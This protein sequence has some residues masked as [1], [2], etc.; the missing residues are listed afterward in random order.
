MTNVIY[1]SINPF[2]LGNASS[3]IIDF[4]AGVVAGTFNALTGT[5]LLH[6]TEDV[7]DALSLKDLADTCSSELPITGPDKAELALIMAEKGPGVIEKAKTLL[8]ANGVSKHCVEIFGVVCAQAHKSGAV[9]IIKEACFS[10][11][12]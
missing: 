1:F 9:N 11:W 4:T 5:K 8:K 3:K 6:T 10:M 7:N 12:V 2:K